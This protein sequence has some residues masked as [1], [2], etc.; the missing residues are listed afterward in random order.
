MSGILVLR[1][2]VFFI[3]SFVLFRLIAE[4]ADRVLHALK[5]LAVDIAVK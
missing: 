3:N 4:S 2:G 1:H 5:A